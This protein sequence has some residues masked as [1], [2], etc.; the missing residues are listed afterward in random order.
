MISLASYGPVCSHENLGI[1]RSYGS[2]MSNNCIPNVS[3]RCEKIC[4]D[5]DGAIVSTAQ[6]SNTTLLVTVGVS[7]L[8]NH[9]HDATADRSQ[10]SNY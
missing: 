9:L 1:I 10:T 5:V 3:S 6:T 7:T 4:R 2:K 8:T